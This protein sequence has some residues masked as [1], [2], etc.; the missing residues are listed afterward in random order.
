MGCP[1]EFGDPS[2]EEE[3][4]TDKS[5]EDGLDTG[6]EVVNIFGNYKLEHFEA[7]KSDRLIII[8]KK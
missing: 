6:M 2:D 8:A 3:V 1:F 5:E 7:S 4:S